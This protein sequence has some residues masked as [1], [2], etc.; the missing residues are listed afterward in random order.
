MTVSETSNCKYSSLSDDYWDETAKGIANCFMV[1]RTT[2]YAAP[3]Q[4]QWER[5]QL[6]KYVTPLNYGAGAAIFLFLTF[7]VT[8]SPRFQV[9]RQNWIS[10]RPQNTSLLSSKRLPLE[11]PKGYLESKREREVQ[12]ALSSMRSITDLLVSVSAGTSG[13]LLLLQA[14]QHTMKQDFEQAPLVSGRSVVADE[15]CTPF[16]RIAELHK[17][18]TAVNAIDNDHPYLRT[19]AT[20]TENC[21]RRRQLENRIRTERKIAEDTPVLIP[22]LALERY[23]P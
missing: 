20:F 23:R 7:R 1:L 22:Y 15:M 8:G 9:W 6:E 3:P 19:F 12:A 14:H 2:W 21:R 16:L 10:P 13:T 11:P 18:D 5:H 17:T 4:Y